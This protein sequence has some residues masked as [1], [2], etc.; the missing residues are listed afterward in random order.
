MID[1]NVHSLVYPDIYGFNL[2]ETSTTFLCILVAC[3]IGVAIYSA[4]LY[5]YL[6]PSIMKR[7]GIGPQESL[8]RP[9]MLAVFFPTIGLFLFGWTSRSDVHWIVSIIGIT[10]YAAGVFVVFQCIFVYVPTSYPQYA[11]SLFAGN[12]FCRSA[13]ACGSIMFAR[14]LYI[15][16]G[17][18]RGVS[19]L[20]G[21]STLGIF[22][23]WALYFFGDNLRKRSKF[24]IKEIS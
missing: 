1:T 6:I 21:C 18:G 14:P 10:L 9:A 4:Y 24:T 8:L 22:G 19:V 17:I 23:I 12:D 3:F 20:G 16:L 2:G 5:Y 11:A 15:N 13:L 7:G